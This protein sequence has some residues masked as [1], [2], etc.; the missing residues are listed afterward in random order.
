MT[1]PTHRTRRPAHRVADA[2]TARG[3]AEQVNRAPGKQLNDCRL[4]PARRARGN[5]VRS[6]FRATRHNPL[7]PRHQGRP[8]PCPDATG[9]SL[10]DD[11]PDIGTRPQP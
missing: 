4:G 5:K 10:A 8:T 7:H 6:H 3:R 9:T 11:P 2:A 1:Q